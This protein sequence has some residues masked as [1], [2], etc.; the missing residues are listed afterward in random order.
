MKHGRFRQYTLLL[1]VQTGGIAIILWQGVPVYRRILAGS[2]NGP[3]AGPTALMLAALAVIVIQGAYWFRVANIPSL[4]LPRHVLLSHSV[5]FLGR[6]SFIFGAALFAAVMY[7]RFPEFE[8]SIPRA[9]V[10][11]GVLFSIFCYSLELEWLATQLNG[12]RSLTS[13][14]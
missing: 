1:L 13:S 10:L 8:T 4:Q 12:G 2:L 14:V 3:A 11:V 7:L 9:A 6:C 5:L